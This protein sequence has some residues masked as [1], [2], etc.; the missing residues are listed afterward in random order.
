M[1][2]TT[3]TKKIPDT[4]LE[5]IDAITCIEGHLSNMEKVVMIQDYKIQ[6]DAGYS[7][8]KS[9]VAVLLDQMDSWPQGPF[10]D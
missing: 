2:N 4:D 1:Q 5:A 8:T 7:V 9:L 10:S 6:R 3:E